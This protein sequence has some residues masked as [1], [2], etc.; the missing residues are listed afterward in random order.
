[1]KAQELR[2]G[3]LVGWNGEIG[4][5][6]QLL[7]MEVA[8]KCGESDLYEALKPIPLTTEI[9]F[10]YTKFEP[11]SHSIFELNNLE[12]DIE[13][14]IAYLKIDGNDNVEYLTEI[15][16][17]HQLQNLYFALNNEELC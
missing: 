11:L 9:L 5:I 15:K 12:I 6:S 14:N 1:M 10:K 7:E 2:I 13:D 8:F 17:L 4:I 16:Y 3:N